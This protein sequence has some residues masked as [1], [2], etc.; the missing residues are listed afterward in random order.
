MKKYL[1]ISIVVVLV[2]AL[3]VACGGQQASTDDGKTAQTTSANT[4][5]EDV[6]KGVPGDWNGD[7]VIT[8]GYDKFS[9]MVRCKQVEDLILERCEKE[10]WKY[11]TT[12]NG[13]DPA[14]A[15][16]NTAILIEKG[17]DYILSYVVDKSAP[18]TI[19]EMCD[20]AGIKLINEGQESP[21]DVLINTSPDLYKAGFECGV[22]AGKK[23][24][25]R[26]NGEV[27]LII[28]GQ[29]P[30]M[31][32]GNDTLVDGLNDGVKSVLP[33]LEE[34]WDDIYVWYD[35]A[36]TQQVATEGAVGVFTANPDAKKII[37][38]TTCDSLTGVGMWNA[39]MAAGRQNDIIIAGMQL[40]DPMS[41]GRL[42]AY[43]DHWVAQT[44]SGWSA[45]AALLDLIDRWIAGE[46]IQPGL[47]FPDN[48]GYYLITKDTAYDYP[49]YFTPVLPETN[50]LE[51]GK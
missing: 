48:G 49:Q 50:E 28:S 10:G 47:Y 21:S 7:G 9:E 25:E 42:V 1:R 46:D 33:E 29:F 11:E 18:L 19:Q 23:A 34:V 40:N 51:L 35:G 15:I 45:G 30:Q 44:L 32:Y 27:D 43:P 41:P 6:V 38:L 20:E 3:L 17:C 16:E 12:V 2:A 13:K 26:W 22:L 36:M 37:C 24:L 8:I 14:K 4:T 39:A 5:V 31:G